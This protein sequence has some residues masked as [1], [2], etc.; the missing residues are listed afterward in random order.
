MALIRSFA[1]LL[2]AN[3]AWAFRR[4]SSMIVD[5]SLRMRRAVGIATQ[6]AGGSTPALSPSVNHS[7][8]V[9][10]DHDGAPPCPDPGGFTG[11]SAREKL[12][13]G[14]KGRFYGA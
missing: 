11:H 13:N 7:G 2:K 9:H 8:G 4:L 5:A 12:A 3:V 6:R 1:S 10:N 14:E